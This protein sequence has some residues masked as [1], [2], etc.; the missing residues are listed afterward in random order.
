MRAL[1]KIY[2]LLPVIALAQS[3][4]VKVVSQPIDKVRKLPGEFTSYQS[5][6]V[7]ARVNGYIEEVTVD[8]GSVVGKGQTLVRLS[9]PE[10]DA[11]IAEA[12]ARVEVAAA[13]KAE[14][15][16]KQLAA[17]ATRDRL[18]EAAKTP[19]AIAGNE[20]VLAEKAV[21]AA[22][23][24]VRSIERSVEAGK[25]SVK[26]LEKLKEFLVLTAPFDGVVT[27]R[28]LHPGALAGPAAGSVLKIEQTGRL[29]LIVAVPETE[30]AGIV[31]GARVGFTVPAHPGETFTGVVARQPRVMDAKTRTMPVELDVANGGLRLAPGMYPEVLWP[32]RKARA[33]L[34]VPPT[35]VVT[36]TERTFVIRLDAAG[37]AQYVNV[38]KG[39]AAGD[40]VEVM[41]ALR[42]G[43][44]LVRRANDEIREGTLYKR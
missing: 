8:V 37:R 2:Y 17:E 3:D 33:A 24:V 16:A 30:V 15:E 21:D 22:R 13:S 20:L 39:P 40:L 12:N 32:V 5:T 27:E 44:T 31:P 43:D 7:I 29:R 28:R 34:L 4:T 11:Q 26:T 41:G 9:A 25:A 18:R 14:A 6:G 38:R 10:L 23:G 1:L 42:E 19:G 35:A 36:T